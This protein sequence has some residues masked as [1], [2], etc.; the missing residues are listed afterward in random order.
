[1]RQH[2]TEEGFAPECGA[3]APSEVPG[4]RVPGL[5]RSDSG[6]PLGRFACW[7]AQPRRWRWPRTWQ[8]G[9]SP[10]S[11]TARAKWWARTA[12]SP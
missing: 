10:S 1:M 7:H 2:P 9:F 6:A 8:S 3:K 11:A 5:W 4:D 12:S